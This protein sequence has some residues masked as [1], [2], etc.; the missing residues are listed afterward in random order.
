MIIV[1]FLVALALSFGFALFYAAIIYWLD[2]YEPEPV[3][4]LA[5]VFGWG[6]TVAFVAAIIIELALGAGTEMLTSSKAAQALASSFLF[7][8]ITEEIAK[9]MA[10]LL[11]FAFIPREFDSLLDGIV[12]AGIVALGFAA[13]ENTVY[14]LGN[15]LDG[16]WAG[17]SGL[18]FMRVIVTGWNHPFFTAFIGIGLAVARLSPNR[19]VQLLA[20]IVGW[21]LGTMAH[22]FY[23]TWLTLV[24]GF[25]VL[26]NFPLFW[27]GWILMFGVIIWS[28]RREGKW[29][30]NHLQAE[31]N[32]GIITPAQYQTAI[33][34]W[35]QTAVGLKALSTGRYRATRR[36]YALCAELALKKQQRS[37]KGNE[38]TN[39]A[40][41]ESLR[42]D[43]QQLSPLAL[44]E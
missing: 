14:L 27:L 24:K 42:A 9:G 23:D 44:A 4:L 2:R 12:Y 26:L 38:G 10:V 32:E 43:L 34:S 22:S 6:A 29:I 20:P 36:F 16:G 15:Y 11:V 7:A 1:A 33:S 40:I 8:P 41:I 17:L 37:L 35:A 5:V 18:F 30:A 19:L 3:P 28:I 21:T 39:S 13:A 31:T 25:L